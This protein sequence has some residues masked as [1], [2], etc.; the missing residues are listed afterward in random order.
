MAGAE[1]MSI[2]SE[3][4][5]T[6]ER[7]KREAAA[8]L[9]SDLERL[10]CAETETE[11]FKYVTD[12]A[13]SIIALL[14]VYA[15]SPSVH[16]QAFMQCQQCWQP[17]TCK[18]YGCRASQAHSPPGERCT[19]SEELQIERDILFA[20][21]HR[22][23]LNF[24]DVVETKRHTNERLRAAILALNEIYQ[25]DTIISDGGKVYDHGPSATIAIKALSVVTIGR[26]ER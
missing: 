25:V 9:A 18:K 15:H 23:K 2:E 12:R 16:V 3:I 5:A 26:G 21:L 7:A 14:R 17:A 24:H 11:F 19:M 10:C 22:L 13:G 1:A 4:D 6:T 20:E 8:R